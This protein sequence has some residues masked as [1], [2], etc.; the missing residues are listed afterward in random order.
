MGYLLP[1]PTSMG[2]TPSVLRLPELRRLDR[3]LGEHEPLEHKALFPVRFP[4]AHVLQQRVLIPF[5][6][7]GDVFQV[8]ALVDKLPF[9]VPPP[10]KISRFIFLI[11]FSPLSARRAIDH[12]PVYAVCHKRKTR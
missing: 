11:I 9:Y 4:G 12:L 1:S 10:E 7:R 3:F 5:D 8:L 2:I 6:L